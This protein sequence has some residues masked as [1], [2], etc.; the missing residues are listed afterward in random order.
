MT[1]VYRTLML[2]IRLLEN[3]F[4]SVTSLLTISAVVP[5]EGKIDKGIYNYWN[6]SCIIFLADSVV[7]TLAIGSCMLLLW[8]L[9]QLSGSTPISRWA[10]QHLTILF[11]NNY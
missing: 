1:K 11:D 6:G 10:P 9:V 7:S 8:L 2:L 5:W 3:M 4:Q